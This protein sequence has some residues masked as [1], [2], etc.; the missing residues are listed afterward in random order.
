VR[1]NIFVRIDSVK[2]EICVRK[3]FAAV[4]YKK[5]PEAGMPEFVGTHPGKPASRVKHSSMKNIV[6][7]VKPI[8]LAM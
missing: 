3:E 7:V 8:Y 6:D 4:V 5:K 2:R 1:W